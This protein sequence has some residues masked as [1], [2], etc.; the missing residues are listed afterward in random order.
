MIHKTTLKD[1]LHLDHYV[2]EQKNSKIVLSM[3]MILKLK[4][5]K[6]LVFSKLL[7]FQKLNFQF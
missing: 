1:K 2:L 4:E 5:L 6:W 3:L 7:H